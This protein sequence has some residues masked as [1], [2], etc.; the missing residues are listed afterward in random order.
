MSKRMPKELTLDFNIWVHGNTKTKGSSSLLNLE[1]NMCCLGQFSEQCG[2]DKQELNNVSVPHGVGCH[3]PFLTHIDNN[4]KEEVNTQLSKTAMSI[5]DRKHRY[6]VA[7]K[8]VNLRELFS[9]I[10]RTITLKNFPDKIVKRI[11]E[12][13]NKE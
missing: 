9:G 8:V 5:N 10:G 1:G 6:G 2:V 4:D 3:I 11:G 7:E 12:L 13:T